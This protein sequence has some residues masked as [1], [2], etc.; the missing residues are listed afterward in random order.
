MKSFE[1][2][3]VPWVKGVATLAVAA[4]IGTV[5]VGLVY[6]LIHS[7]ALVLIVVG[8]VVGVV[9]VPFALGHLVEAFE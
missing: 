4:G 2:W 9:L 7:P 1:D 8:V 6:A 3:Y 5:T